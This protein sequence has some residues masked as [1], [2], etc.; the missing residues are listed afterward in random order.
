MGFGFLGINYAYD[1]W[2]M[3]LTMMILSI[4]NGLTNPSV[5]GAISL[6]SSET[7]QGINLGVTQ[8]MA[9]IGRILGPLLGG[10]LL[11]F[12]FQGSPYVAAFLFAMLGVSLIII[13]YRK[14][15]D[16]AKVAV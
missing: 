15:P 16:K 5:L 4:G 1:L 14:I 7:E 3:A 10:H 2:T 11:Q 8:S 13:N 9:S 6:A 12:A